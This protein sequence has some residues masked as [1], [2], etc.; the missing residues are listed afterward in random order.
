MT[1]HKDI[2]QAIGK[3]VV[4]KSIISRILKYLLI[5]SGSMAIV[6]VAFGAFIYFSLL[7]GPGP[8]EL[9][10][11][12]PFK[13]PK[14]KTEYLAFENKMAKTWPVISEEK[15]IQTSFGST[16]IRI[17]GPADASPLV[18]L[19]GGGSNSYI[20]NANIAAF[21]K[22]YR[23]Y[24]LDNIYDWGRS[25]YTRKI[26][27]GKDFADWLDE[28]FEKLQFDTTL[29]IIGYSYGGWVTSLYALYYPQR[30]NH[31]VLIAPAWTILPVS[32]DW[33]LRAAKS[34][35]PFRTFKK[36]IMY[37]VWSDLAK[38]GNKGIKLIEDRIDYYTIALKCFKLKQGVEPTVLTDTELVTLKPPVL[39]L[40][41]ENE[42]CYNGQE[43]T[44]RLN[45]VAPRIET[46]LIQGTGHDLM[47][48]HTE[49]V[50]KR[51]LE[52]LGN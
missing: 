42:T 38:M 14:A 22:E 41:G 13:S 9:S 6:I 35:L 3:S 31:V 28:L 20:W 26:E 30:L 24:A 11:F 45:K 47:F 46:E 1:V 12:H 49:T 36:E 29:R 44:N 50:N 7:F 23:T 8:M 48:T 39:Y 37:W 52:F 25:V 18:L 32:N 4:R 2:Q 51:I 5:F 21:S 10:E 19:P 27:S 34:L 15:N 16:F 40:V 17:S 43:A 33:L